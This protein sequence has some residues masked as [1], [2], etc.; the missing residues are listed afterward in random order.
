MACLNIKNELSIEDLLQNRDSEFEKVIQNLDIYKRV[1][2]NLF[3]Y[4][5]QQYSLENKEYN[6]NLL[7]FLGLIPKRKKNS[8]SQFKKN[9]LKKMNECQR[10]FKLPM[11][12]T[13]LVYTYQHLIREH[14]IAN[15]SVFWTFLQKCPAR[16]LSG[17]NSFAILLPPYPGTSK[18]FN[19]CNHNCYYCPDQT[20]KNGAK[21][22]MPRSYLLEE[23]AVQRGY[24]NGWSPIKQML[25]RM[26][27]LLVQG[28][29]VDKLEL[30]IEGG[31][32]TEYPPDFLEE[33][34][35]DLFYS[36]NTFY[37][38]PK[39]K[40]L[41]IQQEMNIN[42]LTQVRIIGICIETRPDAINDTW[43][44][45]FRETGTTRIQLGVQH[46]DNKILK[47]INRG[48]TFEDSCR[49]VEYLK[50]NGFKVDIHLMP[51]LPEATPEKDQLMM[52]TVFKTDVIC[53]DQV[54]IYPCEITPY[55]VIKKWY[56]SGK[57]IPY[58]EKQPGKLQE[59][60]ISSMKMC[61]PWVRFPRVVRD[62]PLTL[63]HGGNKDTNLRQMVDD[64]LKDEGVRIMEIRSREI[65]RNLDYLQKGRYPKIRRYWASG[66]WE[67]F[68]SVESWDSQAL[69]GFLRLRIPSK[70]HQPVFSV[71]LGKGLIRELHVYNNLV[72]VGVNKSS[73]TQHQG[74]GKRLLK[75]AEWISFFHGLKGTAVI[76]GEGVRNYYHRRGYTSLQTFAVKTFKMSLLQLGV[77]TLIISKLL[78]RFLKS[79]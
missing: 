34:H 46:T 51:D 8:H 47:K 6:V 40:P 14:K 13:F 11:K 25:D 21:E 53:P 5:Q 29:E 52:E 77:W 72:P 36:A 69:Y 65:G 54:K 4:Y 73:S 33:F 42:I 7:D 20:I 22:D 1:V 3:S 58:S 39:R 70:N 19:G 50:E 55:T 59:I 45:F 18:D 41:S 35:R 67:Y 2:F 17:V 48:H 49:A 61:P 56:D 12:K 66:S 38:N 26:N 31:T 78:F 44:K 57:F 64:Q 23:P 9:F 16:N 71:L 75:I 30:I 37:D 32:Y 60:I 24:R 76:T 79:L 27:S 62:I 74:I 15:D 68:I 28:H 63:I 43:I 10:K